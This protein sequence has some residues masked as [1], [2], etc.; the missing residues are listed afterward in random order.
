MKAHLLLIRK[1]HAQANDDGE[2]EDQEADPISFE[3]YKNL[4]LWSIESKQI[5]DWAFT[6]IQWNVMGRS[7]NIDVLGFHNLTCSLGSDSITIKYDANKKDKAGDNVTPK[8]CYANPKD[9]KVCIFLAL[10]CYLA[11]NQEKFKRASDKI[12]RLN[13]KKGSASDKYCK[14]LRATV[15]DSEARKTIACLFVRLSN[16][17]PHGNRKG[18]SSHVT[19][20]TMEPPPMPSI[21]LRG[22]WSLGKVL[23]IYWR[24]TAQG[25]TYL[26]RLLAGMDHDNVEFGMLPPHFK[27]GR[28]N[29]H[30]SEAMRLCFGPIIDMWGEKCT[31]ESSLL[32][33]LASMVWHQD[34]LAK[35]MT[36][37]NGH[38]FQNIP[39]LQNPVLLR[40]LKQLVTCEPC[41]S[42]SVSSGVPRHIKNMKLLYEIL[43][44]QDQTL[45]AV[46]DLT[47]NLPD[48]VRAAISQK[49]AEA[50][51]VT[52]EYVMEALNASTDSIKSLIERTVDN[53]IRKAMEHSRVGQAEATF[54]EVGNYDDDEQRMEWP[55]TSYR[56]YKHADGFTYAVPPDFE[57]SSCSLRL[58]WNAWL[59]GFP[60]NRSSS[61]AA[62]APVRP[63]RLIWKNT[64]LP[65]G[66]VRNASKTDGSQFYRVW[67]ALSNASLMGR[68]QIEWIALFG[69]EPT[70]LQ[71]KVFMQ[72]DLNCLLKRMKTKAN[73]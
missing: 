36:E 46:L 24:W 38:P 64:L 61:T 20:N 52:V 30:I 9:G 59:V 33:F 67:P 26:G 55:I 4:C 37:T 11:L 32:L 53:S 8:N 34:F 23:D 56:D 70:R 66:K 69:T 51:H 2:T 72:R 63:L 27:E 58:A 44:K 29:K 3:F 65:R 14:S 6:T 5:D 17:H 73:N 47:N 16:F 19:T 71:L 28:E 18:A 39:I 68:V 10:G 43:H 1:E 60:G 48:I 49:A 50:G 7:A 15:M 57:F 54:M 42:I 25:D 21:L 41:N 35:F 13:G 31:I 40:E 62:I 12:F 45:E 22:E